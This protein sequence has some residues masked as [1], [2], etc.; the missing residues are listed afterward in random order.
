MTPPTVT[1]GA[2]HGLDEGV[3]QWV[4]Q[5]LDARVVRAK[6]TFG[7]GTRATWFLGVERADGGSD[8][9]VGRTE[10]G[11]S[12][13][14]GT[15][16]TLA[17]EA[18]VYRALAPTPVRLPALLAEDPEGRALLI[19]RLPG[20]SDLLGLP[21]EEKHA[22][23]LALMDQLAALHACD[24]T[25]LD[26]PGFTHPGTPEEHALVDLAVWRDLARGCSEV[27]PE[28]D[29]ALAWL[30]AHAPT[31][32]DRTVLVQGDT[33]PGNM[34]V[35]EGEVVGLIDWEFAHLGDPHDDLAWLVFRA[36][37]QKRR[38][39]EDIEPYLTRYE[40]VSGLDID[41]ARLAYYQALVQLRCAIT[42]LL[43]IDQGGNLGIA[44]YEAYHRQFVRDMMEA[45]ALCEGLVVEAPRAAAVESEQRPAFDRV[46]TSLAREVRPDASSVAVKLAVNEAISTLLHLRAVDSHGAT[47]GEADRTEL[48][49]L[50]GDVA[51]ERRTE[52]LRQRARVGG[53]AGDP[54]VLTH[55]VQRSR[56]AALLWA[57]VLA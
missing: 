20:T 25:E 55:L 8:D 45:I 36:T 28:I 50:L 43:T 41:R 57:D 24:V 46:L 30:E 3:Q 27:P 21:E 17:R 18:V 9:V 4:E 7:G 31:R 12:P 39:V 16:I 11:Q 53:A 56:R 52:V 49:Q 19:E 33:G 34:M 10:L 40:E 32:V 2:L 22:A 23:L 54:A 35:V 47:L 5:T 37:G 14:T 44:M 29:F 51:D 48:E 13:F 1:T 26:L 38:V 15:P 6:R 42:T